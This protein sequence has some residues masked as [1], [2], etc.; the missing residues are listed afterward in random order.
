MADRDSNSMQARNWKKAD[1]SAVLSHSVKSKSDM[2]VEFTLAKGRASEM[3]LLR[4]GTNVV[5]SIE[6]KFEKSG[7]VLEVPMLYVRL[8]AVDQVGAAPWMPERS[9]LGQLAWDAGGIFRVLKGLV[10]PKEMKNTDSPGSPCLPL[11][12]MSWLSI[13]LLSCLSVPSM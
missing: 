8:K 1:V 10:T 4:G 9:P 13:L 3:T 12:P 7:P 11:L 5:V 2:Q 6:P